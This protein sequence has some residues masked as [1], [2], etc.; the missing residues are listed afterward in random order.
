MLFRSCEFSGNSHA[1]SLSLDY[2]K[3]GGNMSLLGIFKDNVNLDVNKVVFKGL[4]IYGVTGRRMYESWQQID[5]LLKTNKLH[6]DKVVTHHLDFNQMDE[7]FKI[8]EDKSC[9]KIVLSIK[10]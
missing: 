9:G 5:S 3:N 10:E 1:L 4:N 7:A 6:L 2:I 8:M